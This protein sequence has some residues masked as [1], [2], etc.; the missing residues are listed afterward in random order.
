MLV[1]GVHRSINSGGE[2]CS[3][4]VGDG[5]VQ[6]ASDSQQEI[7]PQG[8]VLGAEDRRRAQNGLEV[9]GALLRGCGVRPLFDSGTADDAWFPA[10]AEARP[11]SGKDH[12]PGDAG[13][14]DSGQRPQ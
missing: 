1:G 3:V 9:V 5:R 11:G 2:R 14:S 7:A 6:L 8:S 10:V 4:L 12:Q 13:Q